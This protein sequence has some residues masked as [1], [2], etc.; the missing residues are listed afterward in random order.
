MYRLLSPVGG[1][2]GARENDSDGCEDGDKGDLNRI[3]LH[4]HELAC[5]QHYLF[6]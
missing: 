3:E 6:F 4:E 1:E 5:E 2:R